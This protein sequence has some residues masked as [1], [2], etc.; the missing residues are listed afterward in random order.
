MRFSK[1]YNILSPSGAKHTAAEQLDA[2]NP[3]VVLMRYDFVE[4]KGFNRGTA[5]DLV[6]SVRK[7]AEQQLA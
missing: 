2:L 1:I 7:W 6:M 3:Y 5:Y 4:L